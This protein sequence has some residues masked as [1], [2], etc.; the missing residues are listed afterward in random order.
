MS[1]AKVPDRTA[2]IGRLGTAAA[3][4]AAICCLPYLILKAVWTVGAPVGITDRS[5]L[6]SNGWVA[7][8][9]LMAVIQLAALVLVLALV[10]PWGRRVPVWL[11]LFPV[12][13]GTGLLFQVSVGAVLVGLF[14]PALQASSAS[15]GGI[16]PWVYAMVYSS[17][18]GEGLALAIAFACHV[19]ARWG[20]LLRERTGEVLARPQPWVSSWAQDHLAAMAQAVA[21]LAVAVALVF[22]YWAAGGSFGLAGSQPHPYLGLQASRVAGAVVAV[23]G[24]L[25]L[26]GGWGRQT[27]FWVPATLAWIGSGAVAAFDGL[28]LVLNRL[29]FM[30]GLDATQPAW[31]LFDTALVIK[32]VIGVL[33]AGVAALVLTGAAKNNHR[34][35][36]RR[37]QWPR[38]APHAPSVAPAPPASVGRLRSTVET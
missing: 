13:V 27:R 33:A 18:A 16:Q 17:F 34:A 15:A 3:W 23:V 11:V 26:A 1:A 25:G 8:N 36:A 35:A 28:N 7:A 6:D 5:M 9:A 24:L 20:S 4:V 37:Q 22:G 19:R 10:R 30:F 21:G 31:S 2:G 32:V 12:W 29:F 14:S 38:S